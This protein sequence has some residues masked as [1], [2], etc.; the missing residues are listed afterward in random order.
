MDAYAQ[1]RRAIAMIDLLYSKGKSE[2]AIA[3][4]IGSEFGYTARIVSE[5]IAL[6]KR[7]KGEG[8]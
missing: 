5:R 3:L 2:D 6:I 4:L 8:N 1:K 7:L